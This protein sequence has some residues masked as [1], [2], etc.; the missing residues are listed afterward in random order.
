MNRVRIIFVCAAIILA[1]APAAL[2]SGESPTPK[3][4]W[5]EN[6]KWPLSIRGAVGRMRAQMVSR[7]FQEKHEIKLDGKGQRFLYFWENGPHKV[8]YMLWSISIDTTGY[9]W[10][11]YYGQS[12]KCFTS[13]HH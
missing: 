11:E 5:Q 4:T 8:I 12:D 10:G 9:S 13:S 2:F 1:A 3:A 6:G 7:G